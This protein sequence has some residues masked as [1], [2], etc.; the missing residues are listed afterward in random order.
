MKFRFV[1]LFVLMLISTVGVAQVCLKEI[2][3]SR[4]VSRTDLSKEY[5]L[6]FH[7][8]FR[9]SLVFVRVLNDGNLFKDKSLEVF[10]VN[11]SVINISRDPKDASHIV[12]FTLLEPGK[13]ESKKLKVEGLFDLSLS[14]EYYVVSKR[15]YLE[16]QKGQSRKKDS[17]RKGIDFIT[18]HPICQHKLEITR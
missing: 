15:D 6:T 4:L 12:N 16:S 2:L 5:V 13:E 11:D 7:N 8:P 14:Y 10:L 1:L 9:D 18:S 17:Y 3:S